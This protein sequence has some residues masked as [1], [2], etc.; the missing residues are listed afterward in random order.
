MSS[1]CYI[2]QSVCLCSF[3]FLFLGFEGEFD[4]FFRANGAF[5]VLRQT[6]VGF[7]LKALNR[8]VKQFWYIKSMFSKSR[9]P[10]FS[11]APAAPDM[12]LRLELN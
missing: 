8:G 10:L 3:G 12:W 6:D 4:V 7:P 1:F 2:A 11:S 9:P 5:E